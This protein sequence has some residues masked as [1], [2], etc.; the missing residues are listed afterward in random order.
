MKSQKGITLI[1]LI[2]YMIVMVLVISTLSILSRFF[3]SNK[4]HLLDESRYISEY[5]KF[6]MYFIAD[7]KRNKNA[8]VERK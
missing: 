1:S 3:F 7:A 8:T 4:N 6:N 2:I 5:N